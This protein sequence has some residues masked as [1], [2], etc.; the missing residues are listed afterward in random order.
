LGRSGNL[1]FYDK[2]V[3]MSANK[4]GEKEKIDEKDLSVGKE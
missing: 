1:G 3:K 4:F 2:P